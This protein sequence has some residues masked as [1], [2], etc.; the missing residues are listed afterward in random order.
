MGVAPEEGKVARLAA[1]ELT[2]TYGALRA[3]D[4][5]SV[6]VAPGSTVAITGDSGAGKSTLLWAL[7]GAVR[8]A[9][10]AVLLDG[11]DVTGQ[12][13]P[14]DVG[15]LP[16]SFALATVLSAVENVILPL[17]AAG[18]SAADAGDRATEALDA[19]GVADVA[20]HLVD[21]LSG[22]Q[23][24]RVALA[25]FLAMRTPVLLVDEP[26]SALD[27][28]T[29]ERVLAAL[30][31]AAPS[32]TAVVIATDDAEVAAAANE[33]WVLESGCARRVRGD[34]AGSSIEA[35]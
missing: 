19:L 1:V 29:R 30:H 8:P 18:V 25:R 28:R 35:R 7:A 24:Q 27:V 16:Q 11:V 22:G 33:E 23:R 13:R 6:A 10:G 4:R 17:L 2:V 26:T 9:S 12:R 21:E 5:V 32:G 3:L 14:F 31:A 34:L 20:T 15:L